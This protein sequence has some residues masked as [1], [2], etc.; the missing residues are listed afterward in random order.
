MLLEDIVD[1]QTNWNAKM[2]NFYIDIIDRPI[3]YIEIETSFGTNGSNIEIER[4]GDVNLELINTERVL[5]SDL[6]DDIPIS[7]IVGNLSI[8]RI[9]FGTV[10]GV[11]SVGLNHYLD[12]YEF[13]CGSP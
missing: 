3:Y 2:S 13:D 10:H 9:D 5:A 12:N 1:H 6:P 4:F 11:G 8:E 7:K